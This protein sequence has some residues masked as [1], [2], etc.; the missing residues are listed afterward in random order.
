MHIRAGE[1]A[2][3][4]VSALR[5]LCVDVMFKSMTEEVLISQIL[6]SLVSK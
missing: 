5:G 6:L 4:T 1:T 3:V 2:P